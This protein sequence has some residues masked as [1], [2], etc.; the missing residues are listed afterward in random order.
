MKW[1]ISYGVG[2]ECVGKVYDDLLDGEEEEEGLEEQRRDGN[3]VDE[4]YRCGWYADEG[5][6]HVGGCHVERMLLDGVADV[7]RRRWE[8]DGALVS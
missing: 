7:L 3:G 6:S 8:L 2:F 1:K 5:R 4:K